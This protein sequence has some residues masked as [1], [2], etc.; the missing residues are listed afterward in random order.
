MKCIA[1]TI[2]DHGQVIKR[3]PDHIATQAVQDGWHYIA[4]EAWKR[5]MRKPKPVKPLRRI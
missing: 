4:K 1:K 2:S 5:E 3:V